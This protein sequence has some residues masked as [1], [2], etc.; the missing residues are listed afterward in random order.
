[1]QGGPSETIP[2]TDDSP[3]ERL[4]RLEAVTE[5]SLAHLKLEDLLDELLERTRE[6]LDADT[7]AVLL[8]DPSGR[9]LVATAA[10]G[11]E[12][13]VRQ[14]VRIP[15]GAGF[16]GRVAASR[17]PVM[18]DHVDEST[19]VNRILQ[20]KGLQSLLG[21][22]LIAQNQVLGV[23]HVGTT[24]PHQFT[25]AD[26]ELLQ[27]V[28][29]RIALATQGRVAE[30]ERSAVVSLQRSLLPSRPATIPGISVAARYVPGSGNAIGGDWYDVFPLPGGRTGIVIG[31][32]V[33]RGVRAA[34][35]MGRLRS[36]LRAYALDGGGPA[37]V[38]QRLDRKVQHFE[39][40]EMATVLFGIIDETRR[41]LEVS[42]AGH[43]PP[44]IKGPDGDTQFMEM[45]SD[46]P[47][48]C[49]LVGTRR[50]STAELEPGAIL[51]FFTDGLVERR[52]EHI[53]D[54]LERLRR[55]ALGN[56]PE[57]VSA[58]MMLGMVGDIVSPDDIA[59]VV[60]KR[61]SSRGDIDL[62]LPAVPGSLSSLRSVMRV[63][64]TDNGADP[65]ATNDLLLAV[66]EACM[67]VI[68]HAYGAGGGSMQIHITI[69]GD[70]VVA[71]VRDRGQWRPARGTDR[72]RGIGLMEG[73][74]DA[75]H[76]EH[77]HEGTTVTV[78]RRLQEG[79]VQ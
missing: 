17:A 8:L 54:G 62:D 41:R 35:V 5:A 21:V 2:N 11:L 37:D 12:E 48:G 47:I 27:L 15:L 19:V 42:S 56:T 52:G 71:C 72:G 36:A 79:D 4:R 38:L 67:N 61:E 16:A 14:G 77:T 50:S 73:A 20:E 58:I 32:V 76:V 53:D 7:A 55:S 30:A 43:L 22:P 65:H 1:M 59:L 78:R 49:G 33:G 29:D 57:E 68:E 28:A 10:A 24:R 9:E 25:A 26:V 63:W 70:E 45:Q 31:D 64:L 44:L 40:G 3:A 39:P 23:L 75:V 6:L 74:A 13:E 66:G 18:L 60:V 34:V 46:T 69:E 51:C